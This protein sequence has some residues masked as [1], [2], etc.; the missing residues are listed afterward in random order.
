MKAQ[1]QQILFENKSN[2]IHPILLEEGI[3]AKLIPILN[4]L[5]DTNFMQFVQTLYELDID[6]NKIYN[7]T[8]LGNMDAAQVADL[9]IERENKKIE[10]RKQFRTKPNSKTDFLE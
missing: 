8:K 9:I 2:D 3:K 4:H 10:T 1:I 5:M 6:E 7:I